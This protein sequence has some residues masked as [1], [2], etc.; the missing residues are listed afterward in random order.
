MRRLL[1][2]AGQTV[3]SAVRFRVVVTGAG[4]LA[5]AVVLL[6]L[7]VKHN[8]TARMYAQVMLTY[9]LLI[10]FGLLGFITLWLA[11]GSLAGEIE[12]GQLQLVAVKP[13]RRWQ[14]WLGKWL[15]IVAVNMV[16]LGV[17]VVVTLAMLFGRAGEL[18][19]P[20]RAALNDQVLVARGV[21]REAPTDLARDIE[22]L[23]ANRLAQPDAAGLEPNFVREQMT[24]LARSRHETVAPDYR[25]QWALDFR[26]SGVRPD[27]KLH[28]RVRFHA[29]GRDEGRTHETVWVIGDPVS[30][31][32]LRT[33]RTL[34]AEIFHEFEIPAA[35]IGNDGW[36]R[37]ECENRGDTTLLFPLA[38]GLE[39]LYPAG[40]FASNLLRGVVILLCWLA[41]LAALGLAASSFLSFPTAALV[42]LGLLYVA[43]SGGSLDEAVQEG[44]VFGF[45]HET[46]ERVAG[47]L[48]TLMLPVFRALD[49][50]VN[51]ITGYAPVADLG[52][53]RAIGWATLVE[54]VGRIVVLAGGLCAAVGMIG[55]TRRQLG[56]AVNA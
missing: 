11:C 16:L 51:G 19:A 6:P 37:I 46:S 23:E 35:H 25:R 5:V 55:L 2:I 45:D 8:D 21:V 24:A 4:L 3:L 50:V 29:A 39:V 17:A 26:G 13:V 40:G 49:F 33:P 10:S 15:G 18:P 53:G 34:T 30:G 28:L 12:S 38:D 41:L 36:L 27:Q 7:L 1:A 44:S 32:A 52:A 20:Q 56:L 31:R 42:S 9:N 14:L 47:G 54:A 22:T 43:L 48:D